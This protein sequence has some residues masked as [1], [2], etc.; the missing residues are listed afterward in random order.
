MPVQHAHQ[1]D[2]VAALCVVGLLSFADRILSARL[3]KSLYPA[4][5][6]M[7]DDP[8]Q[9]NA[10]GVVANGGGV[11]AVR[12]DLEIIRTEGLS[13]LGQS[14]LTLEGFTDFLTQS[15][16]MDSAYHIDVQ[17]NPVG[18]FWLIVT[19]PTSIR[20]HLGIVFNREAASKDMAAVAAVFAGGLALYLLLLALFA[21][22][23]SRVTSVRIIRP[24]RKLCEGTRR[25]REGDYTARVHLRL[26]NEFA[27][28]QDT[29]NDM[30]QRIEE[31]MELRR[32]SEE[33][34]K[35]LVLD[36]SHD[37]RNPLASVLGYAEL[38]LQA[39]ERLQPDQAE[40]LRVIQ[41]NGRR[42][43]R[44]LSDLFEL[45]KVESPAFT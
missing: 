28:L 39:P 30:A 37:L 21:F 4:S 16:A 40:A 11:Q 38:C 45:S 13:L 1:G 20:L 43:D 25:L 2:V 22:L 23:F 6:L 44:L 29:F 42:A 33:D 24:L 27:E 41:Q 3:V 34:R 35:R 10:S 7:R 31:Q 18:D 36:I 32:Q 15:K 12:R 8:A 5:A 14:P 26:K 19:F 17:Y 9:I